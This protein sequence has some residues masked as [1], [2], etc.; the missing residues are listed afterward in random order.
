MKILLSSVVIALCFALVAA[1]PEERSPKPQY[2]ASEKL[3]R[4]PDYREWE[5][6]SAGYGMN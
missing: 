6:L 1:A 4:P 5:F 2:D 3:L